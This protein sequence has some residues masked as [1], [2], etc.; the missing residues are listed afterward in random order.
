MADLRLVFQPA[1]DTAMTVRVDFSGSDGG[2]RSGGQPQP[3]TFQLRPDQY[4]DLRWYLEE[5][6]DLPL[7]GSVLRANRIE[8]SLL[9]WGRD[10]YQAVFDYGDHRDLIRD[11][12]HAEPP[13]VLT[14][15]T[16]NVDILRLP[17]EL[18][19]DERGALTRR[20]VTIRRQLETG[21]QHLVYH[22]G[23]PLRLLLV[24]SRPDNAGFIDSR[25]STRAMLDALTSLGSN[26]TVEF[27]QPPT[28]ARLE[29]MLAEANGA[30]DIVHIDGHGNYDRLLGLG[31]LL[32]EKA[33]QPGQA[34]VDMDPV[35]ADDLGNL[36]A[37]YHIP[38]VILEACRTSKVDDVAF[39]SV[40]P[41]LSVTVPTC[42]S[43][44]HCRRH[45]EGPYAPMQLPS[46]RMW[47]TAGSAWRTR[48]T[49]ASGSLRCTV[50]WP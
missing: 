38:L 9:Q 45:S 35:R 31:V 34:G 42:V 28:L 29:E 20:A 18:M 23:S 17:W 32:F 43:I 40:A 12:M 10:L 25:H 24:V 44:P 46:R 27:C 11:L 7:G 47:M 2:M 15:A 33:Q 16:S 50:H 8:Q 41:R 49:S 3:F 14:I 22:V 30:Y 26:V 21:H 6:M 36:L 19:A 39:R 48:K 1:P 4:A 13:R 37:R 5:F